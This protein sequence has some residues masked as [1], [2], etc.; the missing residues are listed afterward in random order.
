MCTTACGLID[1]AS[2]DEDKGWEKGGGGGRGVRGRRPR[3]YPCGAGRQEAAGVC[4]PV[5]Q[6]RY[7]F[8][9]LEGCMCIVLCVCVCVCVCV[10]MCVCVCVCVCLY[11]CV[12]MCVSEC[13]CM[14]V[15]VFIYKF[16][17]AMYFVCV[18]F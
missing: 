6:V 10:C 11:V 8:A 5:Q 15:C 16:F 1:L 18:F 7:L 13:V 17:N 9:R 12:C 4:V 2:E 3:A 14:C